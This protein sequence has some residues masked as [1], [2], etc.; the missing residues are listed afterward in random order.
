MDDKSKRFDWD[1]FA[2]NETN[3]KKEEQYNQRDLSEEQWEHRNIKGLA[4]YLNKYYAAMAAWVA[5]AVVVPN[6][7]GLVLAAMPAAVA[8]VAVAGV[9]LYTLVAG[10]IPKNKDDK[11]KREFRTEALD[12]F[13]HEKAEIKAKEFSAHQ[14]V[15]TEAAAEAAEAAVKEEMQARGAKMGF[16][17]V[18]AYGSKVIIPVE[19]PAS[20]NTSAVAEEGEFK[21]EE[22]KL[23]DVLSDIGDKQK[24]GDEN[25]DLDKAMDKVG[26]LGD[27]KPKKT[28]KKSTNKG[29]VK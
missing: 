26:D 20:E 24:A 8:G 17:V 15:I 18:E 1:D 14:K 13:K 16:K 3:R 9:G 29:K 12:N 10:V 28:N 4:S 21:V 22:D 25:H 19:I 7:P 2:S 23:N 5:V 27:E 6:F 11:E